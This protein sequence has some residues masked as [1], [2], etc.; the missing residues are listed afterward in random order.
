MYFEGRLNLVK[1]SLHLS[2]YKAA[3]KYAEGALFAYNGWASEFGYKL[4][5]KMEMEFKANLN[6]RPAVLESP[7][8]DLVAAE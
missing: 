7:R 6:L 2:R 5:D 1:A 3:A 4:P 8:I